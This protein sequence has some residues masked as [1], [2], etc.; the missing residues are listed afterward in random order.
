MHFKPLFILLLAGTVAMAISCRRDMP[1][2]E[3]VMEYSDS[4]VLAMVR[5]D[6]QNTAFYKDIFLDGGCELNPGIKQNGQVI[7]GRLPYALKK[8]DITDAEYFLATVNDVSEGY[9]QSDL[10]L[11]TEIISGTLTDLNGV[12]LYPD[13]EPRFRMIFVFGGHSNPHGTTL[14]ASGRKRIKTFYENGGSYVGSCAGAFLAGAYANGRGRNYFNILKNSDMTSTDVG[15]S[16]IDMQMCSDVFS[17]YYGPADGSLIQGIRHNGGGFLNTDGIPEGTEIIAQFKTEAGN[18]VKKYYYDQP[19]IWAYKASDE[20]GRLVVT[21]SHPEDA[22]S[23]D[24]LNLT[25]SMMRYAWDGAGRAKV[26]GVLTKGDLIPVDPGIGDLQ[27]HHFVLCPAADVKSLSLSV[28]YS[29]D[30]NLEIYI[31]R[32]SFA[33]PDASP[34]YSSTGSSDGK[35]VLS[36]GPLEK[37]LWYVTVRC[38]TTV[39]SREHTIDASSGLG[40]YFEYSGPTGVLN[41]VPYSIMAEWEY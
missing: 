10:K 7:N 26:K 5:T 24:I 1:D 2:I 4:E 34:D 20:S 29:G 18:G 35:A 19:S 17:S 3:P 22:P 27:C 12:L 40:R 36:T 6:V 23:G 38:S 31:K 8:A 28:F 32:D 9:T 15:N 21:G 14:G 25:A 13:G 11:Q 30:Y 39:D 33:F 37:G 41:G 16:S